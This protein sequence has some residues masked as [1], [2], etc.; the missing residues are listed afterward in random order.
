MKYIKGC[1]LV[2]LIMVSLCLSDLAWARQ[3]PFGFFLD[4][5]GQ[6]RQ[7]NVL[8]KGKFTTGRGFP[9]YHEPVALSVTVPE[10]GK[11][12]SQIKME[13]KQWSWFR[14]YAL[15]HPLDAHRL[16]M[17]IH[18][19]SRKEGDHAAVWDLRD[20]SL[21]ILRGTGSFSTESV[22]GIR[23]D[24]QAVLSCTQA[25]DGV[26]FHDL[27]NATRTRYYKGYQAF[28]PRFSPDGTRWAFIGSRDERYDLIIHWTNQ[29][30]DRIVP[31]S[32]S[33]SSLS[34]SFLLA[35]A[36]SGARI[37]SVFHTG[38]L[39]VWDS[40]GNLV[41]RFRL[42]FKPGWQWPPIWSRDEKGVFILPEPESNRIP[43]RYKNPLKPKFVALKEA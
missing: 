19:W 22:S 31:L 6:I 17:D 33:A 43:Y 12:L 4:E 14:Y 3:E 29:N 42:P 23:L 21:R 26:L 25:P 7:V 27:K 1:F 32:S 28:S 18:E 30:R 2:A 10:T 16:I 39:V 8:T 36:P 40:E 41:Q 35:W 34:H 20:N 15:P 13:S 24:E 11:E 5:N 37:A 9:Y 38:E